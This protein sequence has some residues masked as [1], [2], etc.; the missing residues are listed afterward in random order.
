MKCQ[1]YN[2]LIGDGG[3]TE[4]DDWSAC[5]TTCGDG[6]QTSSRSCTNPSQAGTGA[7][8]EGENTKTQKCHVTDCT[9]RFNNV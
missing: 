5:S 4:W 8:C 2:I 6:I 1:L 7:L 9:C 3:W